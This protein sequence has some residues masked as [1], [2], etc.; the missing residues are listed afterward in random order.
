M[1]IQQ[2]LP[3]MKE[4]RKI[5]RA[6]HLIS[7]YASCTKRNGRYSKQERKKKAAFEAAFFLL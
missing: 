1:A 5:A 4:P 6:R 2:L 3:Y 7:L